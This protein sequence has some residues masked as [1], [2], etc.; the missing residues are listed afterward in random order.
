METKKETVPETVQNLKACRTGKND[1]QKEMGTKRNVSVKKENK[2]KKRVKKQNI[3]DNSDENSEQEIITL[4]DSPE[5]TEW[6]DNEC[7]G[8]GENYV[9][10]PSKDEWLQCTICERWSHEGCTKYPNMCDRCGD[11]MTN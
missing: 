9:D 1:T 7:A 5:I 11:T 3:N 2:D 4:R 6:D 8:C 10:T